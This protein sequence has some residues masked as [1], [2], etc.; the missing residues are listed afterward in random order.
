MYELFG[1]EATP[2]FHEIVRRFSDL[3]I[4]YRGRYVISSNGRM[5]IP[6][7]GNTEETCKLT[8]AVIAG[9]L[10]RRYAVAVYAGGHASKFVCFDV[11]L[12]DKTL[13]WKL[14]DLLVDFGFP[15]DRI[16]VSTS[17]GKGFHVEMFFTD[18]VY[19]NYLID[20]YETICAEGSFD[21][22]KVEFRPTA[23]MSIK[24]PLSI[25]GKTGNV[26]WY[27]D[28][29]TLEPI[30]KIEY[31]MSI[32]QI[33]RDW[34]TELIKRKRRFEMID[35]PEMSEE[36]HYPKGPKIEST[37]FGNDFPVLL[38]EGTRHN[39]MVGIGVS[40]R[41][42]GVAQEDIVKVL[43]EWVDNQNQ[44]LIKSSRQEIEDD[45]AKIA[46]WVWGPRF[47]AGLKPMD[48]NVFF[49]E[50]DIAAISS[51][52]GQTQR[53]VLFVIIAFCRRFKIATLSAKRIAR[54]VG[55]TERGVMKAIAHIE[56]RGLISHVGGKKVPYNGKY[57]VT[58]NRY[59]YHGLNR[60]AAKH[61]PLEWDFKEETF[62][63]TYLKI[64]GGKIDG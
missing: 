53:R 46:A 58:P 7:V 1:I 61:I 64:L 2:T 33:D 49:S 25:H 24:L 23:K 20:M 8:D 47:S 36:D 10:N 28:P 17:G 62:E 34:A 57:I 56:E 35:C 45:A 38:Q 43:M 6:H 37:R 22:K 55:S 11:D 5:H 27:L 40:Q 3:Y 32:Q 51:L 39:L 18:T 63:R 60:Y 59:T 9:H 48:K 13:V 14:I 41:Y 29:V 19:T 21:T 30:K 4:N 54:Y 15:R 31:V 52:R 12:N 26:C 16:Y 42:L 50:K 44:S